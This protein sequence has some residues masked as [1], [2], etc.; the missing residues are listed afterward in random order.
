MDVSLLIRLIDQVS[1]PAQK[2][3]EALGSI[4]DKAG[5][6][7]GGFTDSI[8]RGFSVENIESATRNAEVALSNSRRRLMGAAGM[9]M[10]LAAPVYAAAN[11]EAQMNNVATLIDTTAENMGAMRQQVLD[12]SSR[13]PVALQDLTGALY[14]V[15]SAGI[16]AGDAMSVLEGSAR[17][18]IAGLGTTKEAVDL[19]TSSINAFNLE[20]EDQA[21]I[22]DIIFKAVQN[23]KTTIA[24]LAQGFG[25]VAGT[26]ANANIEFDE[27]FA[28]VAALTTTGLP[29]AQAH[30]QIKAAIAGVTRE[31]KESKEVFRKLGAESFSDLVEKSGG[32]VNAFQLISEVLG[33]NDA[34]I[35]KLFGS[36]EAYNAVIALT[37]NQNEAY[38]ATLH[39]MREG[40]NAVD[41][42]FR[43]QAAGFNSQLRLMGNQASQ[44]GIIIGNQLLPVLID[45]LG[46]LRPIV[47]AMADWMQANPELTQTIVLA[48]GALL[49]MNVA[50]R[51]LQFA[52]AGI[53][54][55]LIGLVGSFLKFDKDGRNVAA[56]WRIM[57]G[58]GRILGSALGAAKA[59][60]MGLAGLLAG[61]SAPAWLAIGALV[62][63]G[64][65]LWKYWDSITSFLSGFAAPFAE[66][67]EPV[68]EGAIA[69]VNG[70][71]DTIGELLGLD[72]TSI[73]AFKASLAGLFDFSG[74]IEG[75]RELL[76]GFWDWL[77]GIFS[78]ETLSDAEQAAMYDAGRQLAEQLINGIREFIDSWIQ[79]IR[80][81]FSFS[82]EI[83]WPEPPG[84]LMWLYESGKQ[85]VSL[86]GGL[87]GGDEEEGTG[88]WF[89]GRNDA[90]KEEGG[91]WFS[92][93]FGSG[94][95]EAAEKIEQSGARA[96]DELGRHANDE[97]SRSVDSI[98]AALGRAAAQ[99]ISRAQVNVRVPQS[100]T[101][102]LGSAISNARTGALHGGTE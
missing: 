72:E 44:L 101:A 82:L 52:I 84:W 42:A 95:D 59:G 39:D 7:A 15:R 27:Y 9:L 76:G 10:T 4:G 54:L 90:P 55:P 77:G 25:A 98:G 5:E 97:L 41:E 11:F 36:V 34:A 67:F 20:S 32:M 43:I 28:A 78:R 50:M 53:R 63:A 83:E 19:V 24:E 46:E 71:I 66:L 49:A 89:S 38:L 30:T 70:L 31:T 88:G 29:A 68:I 92:G 35:I 64:F 58:A 14:D 80:D 60:A 16:D 3:G 102:G 65:A 33:G 100:G 22:Y 56:G 61:I 86:L 93:W 51:L 1:E 37:G 47:Q 6:M 87:F 40:A 17:L 48:V 2:V 8:K 99:E 45:V 81:M 74:L 62:A 69:L 73:E 75:A 26:V 13:V 57:A 79:P 85:G 21:R 96:G 12:I 18:A 91:G 23:G 94:A